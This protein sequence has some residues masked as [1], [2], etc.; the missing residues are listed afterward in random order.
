MNSTLRNFGPIVAVAAGVLGAVGLAVTGPEVTSRP[1]EAAIPLVRTV[2]AE[3]GEFAHRVVTHGTVQPRTESELVPEVSGRIDWL[4]SSFA[5]GG[6]FDKDEVLVRIEAGDYLIA[7]KRAKANLARSESEADRAAKE[8]ARQE[9]LAEQN[10][11]SASRLDDARN[12]QKVSTAALQ[13][14]RAALEQAERDLGRTEIRAPF[15]GR[16]RNE[17]VDVGQFV[18][19]G[20]PIATIYA[21]DYAEVR[22]PV[23][24]SE[25][26]YLDLPQLYRSG[27]ADAEGPEVRL[28][29]DFAGGHYSWNGRIVRTEG[30]IDPRTRMVNVVARVSSPYA[31]SEQGRPPLAAGLFVEAEILGRRDVSVFVLPRAALREDGRILIVDEEDRL[32]WRD[33]ELTRADREQIVVS[34]GIAVDDRVCISALESAAEGQRVR[35]RDEGNAPEPATANAERGG[36]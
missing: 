8:L 35:V 27:H 17:K 4:A 12:A 21:V 19:R 5:S 13:E 30:E 7:T 22:L 26:A 24:D 9:K 6:F 29:T 15:E 32:R 3:S 36:A 31:P 11:A 20:A 25:L 14:A 34:G 1:P 2:K 23:P 10:V 16:V 28:H 18:N 33:V